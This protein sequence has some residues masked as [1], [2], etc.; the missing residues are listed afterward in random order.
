MKR[1]YF[2]EKYW[3]YAEIVL[4]A[5]IIGLFIFLIMYVL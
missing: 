5:V 4:V 2:Y 1:K 3:E